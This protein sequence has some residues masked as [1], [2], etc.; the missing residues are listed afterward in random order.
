MFNV[1][2]C[3]KAGERLRNKLFTAF[4]ANA[5]YRIGSHSVL[6]LP[7]RLGGENRIEIGDRVFVG[8]DS[9]LEVFCVKGSASGP[10]IS[11]GNGTSMTGFCTITAVRQ[12]II[13]AEVL[14][15]RYVY[16]S[17][18]SH[19]YTDIS[20]A[21]KLQ[22]LTEA[23]PVRVCRGAWIGQG[24]VICPGVTIGRNSVIGANSVV[25][26]DIEDY[27]VAAGSPARIIRRLAPAD[28]HLTS[29]CSDVNKSSI[30]HVTWERLNSSREVL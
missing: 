6:A 16:I 29:E 18:H 24:V 20:K 30:S 3:C 10:V 8:R 12:V 26:S 7:I 4:C 1:L 5:F 22:G 11:I 28:R 23:A 21:I 13:E 25:R 15:A 19:Q 9:W 27:C 17:D 14:I 2:E